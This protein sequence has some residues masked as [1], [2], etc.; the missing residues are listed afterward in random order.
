MGN[1][2]QDYPEKGVYFTERTGSKNPFYDN[3][4]YFFSDIF[5][6]ALDNG[7]RCVLTWNIAIDDNG[8]PK[9]PSVT[10]TEAAGLIDYVTTDDSWTLYP[11]YSAIGHYGRFVRPGAVRLDASPSDTRLQTV[12]FKNADGTIAVIVY[13]NIGSTATFDLNIGTQH[14]T[15]S[16]DNRNAATFLFHELDDLDGNELSDRWEITYFGD[17]GIDPDADPDGDGADNRSEYIAGTDPTDPYNRLSV[18]FVGPP[19]NGNIKVTPAVRSDFRSWHIETSTNLVEWVPY[20]GAAV[21]NTSQSEIFDLP[22]SSEK[23]MFFRT[24]VTFP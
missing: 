15:S 17:W 4:H 3:M 12:A 13:N 10:W 14:L 16:L 7:A 22:D 9:L 6:N 20:E 23:T 19:Q 11:E 8:G 5:F 24:N 21:S 2:W 1:I 18:S